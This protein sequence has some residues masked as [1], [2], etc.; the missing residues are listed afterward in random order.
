MWVTLTLAVGLLIL[1]LAGF[2]GRGVC[3]SRDVAY[4]LR[5]DDQVK[6][7]LER[8]RTSTPVADPHPGTEPAAARLCAD[9]SPNSSSTSLGSL[10]HGPFGNP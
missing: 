5:I 4:T 9:A 2:T 3:D 6:A 7:A 1:A 8:R 10:P